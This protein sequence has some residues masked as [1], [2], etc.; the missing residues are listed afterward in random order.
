MCKP[1]KDNEFKGTYEAQ[2]NQEKLSR[3][4]YEDQLDY[5]NVHTEE[6]VSGGKPCLACKSPIE[7]DETFDAFYCPECKE[8]VVERNYFDVI[9]N[10]LKNGKCPECNTKIEGVWK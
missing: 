6:R 2:T 10:H 9:K 5:I 3:D 7:Y 8:V 4:D 1:Y